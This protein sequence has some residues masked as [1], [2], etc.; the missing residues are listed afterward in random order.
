MFVLVH[1]ALQCCS[2]R[3]KYLSQR[4]NIPIIGGG[5]IGG[6]VLGAADQKFL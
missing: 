6:L 2:R 5:G 4:E 1:A 3:R